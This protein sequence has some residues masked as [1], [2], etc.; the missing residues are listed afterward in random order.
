MERG[1]ARSVSRSALKFLRL[2]SATQPRA[3]KIQ[4]SSAQNCVNLW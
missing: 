4:F 2:V 3:G 1:C